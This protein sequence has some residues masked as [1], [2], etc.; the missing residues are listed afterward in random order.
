MHNMLHN[1]GEIVV[2]SERVRRERKKLN[3]D[4]RKTCRDGDEHL[5]KS[6][7]REH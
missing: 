3:D 5:S 7:V 6:V 4:G 1:S 2:V